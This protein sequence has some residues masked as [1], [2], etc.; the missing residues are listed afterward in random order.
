MTQLIVFLSVGLVLSSSLVF[1]MT[2]RNPRPEGG[3]G[4]L[5]EARQALNAL[6]AGL[7]PPDLVARIFAKDD[8]EYVLIET[9][10][11]VQAL[12]LEERKKT[13]L[14]WVDQVRTQVISLKRFHLGSARFYAR[15]SMRTEIELALSF[16][17]LLAACRALQ[18]VMYVWGP[19]AAPKMVGSTAAAAARVCKISEASLDFL[20]PSHLS[21]LSGPSAGTARP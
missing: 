20:N 12:F 11:K 4:A 2:R 18:V 1:L 17:A 3:S 16:T 5:V 10:K 8:L 13:A 6:Q 21:S 9:P 7:L 19:Y 14:C 15:L